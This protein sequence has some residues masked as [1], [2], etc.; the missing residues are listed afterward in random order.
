MSDIALEIDDLR[1]WY[2]ASQALHGVTMEVRRGETVA[3]LGRN[4]AGKS[5]TLKAVIGELRTR[6]GAIRVH[7]KDITSAP[8]HRVYRTGLGYVPEDRGI[9]T[10][11]TVLENLTLPPLV[12]DQGFGLEEIFSLFPN[13]K[14]RINSFGGKLS[15]GEQQML[16]IARVLRTGADILLLDEPTEG[17]APVIIDRIS[18]VIETLKTRGITILLVEQNLRF[19]GRLSDRLYAMEDGRVVDAFSRTDLESRAERISAVL[20]L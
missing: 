4:G 12:N 14:S 18:E 17:L 13:L 3:V 15:G 2:G 11:L 8:L 5:T 19:A 6:R 9:F 16:A 1:A 7:G 10:S 20:G